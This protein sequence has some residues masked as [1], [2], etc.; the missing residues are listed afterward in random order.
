MTH[1][2]K[3]SYAKKCPPELK[4]NPAIADAVK[5][6]VSDGK[7]SSAAASNVA[8]KLKVAPPSYPE[9]IEVEAIFRNSNGEVVFR[10]ADNDGEIR[11]IEQCKPDYISYYWRKERSNP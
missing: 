3:K 10:W 5:Q 6:G 11:V 1:K 2:D 8:S 7:I 9:P 4:L